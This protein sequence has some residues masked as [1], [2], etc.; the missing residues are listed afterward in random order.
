MDI[1]AGSSGPPAGDEYVDIAERFEAIAS[2]LSVVVV[3]PLRLDT[4][5]LDY[6]RFRTA[7]VH[8]VTTADD[9]AIIFGPQASRPSRDLFVRLGA[10]APRVLVVAPRVDARDIRDALASGVTSYLLAGLHI[11]CL[12]EAVVKTALG[13]TCLDP[14]VAAALAGG[15]LGPDASGRRPQA[16]EQPDLVGELTPRE[17]QI[18]Q[19]IATGYSATEVAA[20]L[21]LKEH[22]VRNNLTKIY[23]KLQ[24]RRQSEAVMLW[25]GHQPC[26][27]ANGKSLEAGASV[28]Q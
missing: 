8:D 19:L 13:I 6:I 14:K 18:M 24:V 17:T 11:R 12:G 21:L 16:S 28:R 5:G 4:V 25:L 15:G 2:S 10:K 26:Q 9:V 22:T 20:R 27:P 3:N 23:A 7:E 1:E